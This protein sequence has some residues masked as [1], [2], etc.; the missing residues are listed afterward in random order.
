MVT[1]VSPEDKVIVSNRTALEDKYGAG[2]FAKIHKA[3]QALIKADQK[4]GLTT[5]IYYIDDRRTMDSFGGKFLQDI[6]DTVIAKKAIDAI[7]NQLKPDYLMVLGSTDVIPHQDVNN[8]AYVRGEDDDFE[9]WGDLPYA[10]DTPFDRDP[11]AFV[12]PTRVVGRMPDVTGAREPSHLLKLLSVATH[13]KSRPRQ[14][15]EKYFAL[16]TYTARECTRDSLKALFG[17]DDDILLAPPK[18]PDAYT[19]GQLSALAHFINC[20]GGDGEPDFYG[21]KGWKE[22]PSLSTRSTLNAIREGTVASVEACYGAQLYDPDK[23]RKDIPICQSYLRQGAYGFFG[24]STTAYGMNGDGEPRVACADLLCTYFLGYVLGGAS[25]GRA[26]LTARHQFAHNCQQT[27][28]MD[29][30]TLSQF[31]LLGDPSIQPVAMTGPTDARTGAEKHQVER[32]QRRERRAKLAATGKFLKDSKP[33]ASIKTRGIDRRAERQLSE[34]AR[35]AGLPHGTEF[36]AY[37]IDNALP[38]PENKPD[39]ASAPTRYYLAIRKLG[40]A[41]RQRRV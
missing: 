35:K 41:G 7:Y 1:R 10:C 30:K 31:S 22:P 33:T 32:F 39:L 40:P 18:R 20:H 23:E 11:A 14:D 9:A 36:M 2:G 27:D 12:G 16:S 28:P 29:L 8:A 37:K 13:W 34:I 17:N 4:R 6:Q 38:A 24:S 21:Q 26:A 5:K 25:I 3:V 19:H 15:Y